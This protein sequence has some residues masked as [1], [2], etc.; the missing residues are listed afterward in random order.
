VLQ[1]KT[2]KSY[3]I[4]SAVIEIQITGLQK[5]VTLISKTYAS[6]A[7]FLKV[8][9]I[10]YTVPFGSS[11]NDRSSAHSAKAPCGEGR[12]Q[13]RLAALPPATHSTGRLSSQQPRER[14]DEI[15]A[16]HARGRI[17]YMSVI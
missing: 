3:Q 12:V 4:S 1:Q 2:T 6:F 5:E 14:R 15:R 17:V 7:E 13:L 8:P 9:I 16:A 10:T 11:T